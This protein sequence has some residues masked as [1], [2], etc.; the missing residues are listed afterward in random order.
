MKRGFLDLFYPNYSTKDIGAA[1][2]WSHGGHMSTMT[3][4]KIIIIYKLKINFLLLKK[5]V[6]IH[7]KFF[8]G[9]S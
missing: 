9:P 1:P 3:W 8:L 4:K 5:F 6:I 2:N 7:P